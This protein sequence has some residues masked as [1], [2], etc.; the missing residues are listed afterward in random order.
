MAAGIRRLVRAYGRR[1]AEEGDEPELAQLVAL[2]AELDEA[3]QA[4]VDGM[5]GR[6]RDISWTWIG[7]ALGITRQAAYQRWG[8]GR[9]RAAD[10]PALAASPGR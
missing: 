8:R 6:G 4:A 7:R 9:Q 2:R 5:R 10:A 1:V 3:I